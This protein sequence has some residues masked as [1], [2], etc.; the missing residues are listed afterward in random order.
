V[1]W[2]TH[3]TAKTR[4][5]ATLEDVNEAITTAL[6]SA[7]AYFDDLWRG[8]DSSD[9]QRS[10]LTAL[11][12]GKPLTQVSPSVLRKLEQRELIEKDETGYRFRVEM[13]RMWVNQ[14]E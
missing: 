4:L 13:V 1:T 10:A 9:E 3:S 12:R 6:E 2:S 7:T 8:P 14:A 5:Y 11:A